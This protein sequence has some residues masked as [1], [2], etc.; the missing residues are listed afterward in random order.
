MRLLPVVAAAVLG[1]ALVLLLLRRVPRLVFRYLKK[2]K[3]AALREL[4]ADYLAG[5]IMLDPAASRVNRI[6]DQL[7]RYTFLTSTLAPGTAS[8]EDLG[9]APPGV[10]DDDPRINELFQRGTLLRFGPKRYRQMLEFF[11]QHES[12]GESPPKSDGG[13]A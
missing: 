6:M 5:H 3:V 4:V 7:G 11:R 10:R 12:K 13:A 2:R 9:L 1:L 8:I